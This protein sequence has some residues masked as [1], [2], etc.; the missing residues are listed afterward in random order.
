MPRVICEGVQLRVDDVWAG[1]DNG[2]TYYL[3]LLSPEN[4]INTLGENPTIED[5][6]KLRTQYIVNGWGDY[7]GELKDQ[8]I[9]AALK[10]LD[11]MKEEG[12]RPKG[13]TRDLVSEMTGISSN[14]VF[15]YCYTRGKHTRRPDKFTPEEMERRDAVHQ[16]NRIRLH[17]RYLLDH[18]DQ[19]HW[20]ELL[21]SLGTER[22]LADEL[23]AKLQ[24]TVIEG[25]ERMKKIS[26]DYVLEDSQCEYLGNI[27]HY[28]PNIS[29]ED[30]FFMIMF[31]GSALDIDR[32]M[33]EFCKEHDIQC[34]YRYGA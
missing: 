31:E 26:V 23:I 9:E 29:E 30:L 20:E 7:S 8:I 5:L 25:D 1:E 14:Y 21:K 4:V 28:Y 24:K 33:R 13:K 22:E 15:D 34:E 12:K 11:R 17:M 27:H 18:L 2:K 19:Y 32:K 16:M 6:A 10:I 3:S